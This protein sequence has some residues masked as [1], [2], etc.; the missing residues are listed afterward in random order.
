MQGGA[1]QLH[2]TPDRKWLKN[3]S[4]FGQEQCAG[5]EQ[6]RGG[7]SAKEMEGPEI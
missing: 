6:K 5:K 2:A 3:Q 7:G 1:I 4:D